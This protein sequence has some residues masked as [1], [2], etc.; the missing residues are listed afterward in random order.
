M[1]L[2]A[3]L[4][5]ERISPDAPF[6]G[7][8]QGNILK[9]HGRDHTLSVF[10]HFNAG[11]QVKAK[12]WLASFTKRFVPSASKQLADTKRYKDEGL[13]GGLFTNVFLTNKCYEYL[14]IPEAKRPA[15]GTFKAGMA[16]SNKSLK[17]SIPGLELPLNDPPVSDWERGFDGLIHVM[18][19]IAD[20]NPYF[21]RAMKRAVILSLGGI[22]TIMK[23]QAGRGLRNA[24]KNGIE[25]NGYADGVS[26][27]LFFD[28]DIKDEVKNKVK[29]DHWQPDA[30]LK[31]AL[32]RDKGG[33]TPDSCGSYFVFRKL[34]QNV[35][36]FKDKEIELAKAL[37][38]PNPTP[39]QGSL[40]GAMVVG[41]FE[42]GTPLA[43]D[44]VVKPVG[45]D[46]IPNDYTFEA[47]NNDSA[48]SAGLRCPFHAH[49]RKNNPRTDGFAP[50]GTTPVAANKEHRIVRRGIPYEDKPRKRGKDGLL[51]DAVQ[52]TGDVGLLFMCFQADILNQFEFIQRVWANNEDFEHGAVGIGPIV[53][54]TTPGVTPIKQQWPVGYNNPNNN[55]VKKPFLFTDVT[56]MK[57]G[58]YFFAPSLSFLT[59]LST[60]TAIAPS[61]QIFDKLDAFLIS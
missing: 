4:T 38:G 10:F 34:E 43:L 31:L 21:V 8:L 41:R 29:H 36:G 33:K 46:E 24:D 52:P 50:P 22:A 20:D 26:Q 7:D 12:A 25:H 28:Q 40:A 45:K 39:A 61:L 30:P 18:V 27:P 55:P 9:G 3:E 44:G 51:D 19:L 53:G 2:S 57:G 15:D 60:A 16:A 48:D 17:T 47:P 59:S 11:Q 42:N 56:K 54:D 37:F 58:E 13:P 32:V 23:E 35:K 1:P 5:E 49:T 6:L 14:A